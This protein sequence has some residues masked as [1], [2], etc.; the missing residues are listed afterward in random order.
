TASRRARIF[1]ARVEAPPVRGKGDYSHSIRFASR[2]SNLLPACNSADF[3]RHGRKVS[4]SRQVTPQTTL[5]NLKRE[6]KRWLKEL[7]ENVADARSRL[8]RAFPNAPDTPTLRDV[9]HALALEHG[10][11][12]WSALKSR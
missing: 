6:A 2:A 11:P 3:R 7:R 10:L 5:D 4:M 8:N 9:Q 1:A 12:G